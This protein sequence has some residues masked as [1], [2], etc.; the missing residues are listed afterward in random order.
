MLRFRMLQQDFYLQAEDWEILLW[1]A[2]YHKRKGLEIFKHKAFIELS[3][4][5]LRYE[6]PRINKNITT[7]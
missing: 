6:K 4:A 1:R 2:D 7:A 5:S 3:K